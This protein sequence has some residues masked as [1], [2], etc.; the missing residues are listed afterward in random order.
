MVALAAT[1]QDCGIAG[2]EAQRAG[3][4]G[5]VRATLVDDPDHAQRD[6]HTLNAQTVRSPQFLRHGTDRVGE[7]RNLLRAI[8]HG[9][10]AC[11]VELETIEC[12]AREARR[13]AGL[14][15]ARVRGQDLF[16][17]CPQRGRNGIER[18]VAVIRGRTGEH[19][20]GLDGSTAHTIHQRG[21]FGLNQVSTRSSR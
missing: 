12:G 7:R 2:L 15:V 3:V 20:L 9:G 10:D 17:V 8:R 19:A 5:Y 11:I 14:H 18:A 13:L 4:A 16:A 6:A 1:A 21:H